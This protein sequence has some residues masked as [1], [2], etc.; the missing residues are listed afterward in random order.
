MNARI[1]IAQ[2]SDAAGYIAL[3]RG[4]LIENPPVDTPYAPEEFDPPVARIRERIAE[5]NAQPNSGWWMAVMDRKIVGTLTCGGGTLIADRHNTAL[6]IYV[7]KAYRDG[8]IGGALM[9]QAM[10]WAENSAVVSRVELEVYAANAR[11]IHLYEKHG[12]EIEGRKRGLYMRNGE[13]M[14]MLLMARLWTRNG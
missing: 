11:A 3:I 8:G 1:R 5:V 6:G 14:D 9:V 2:P 7:A 4:I 12:F 13:A 10:A